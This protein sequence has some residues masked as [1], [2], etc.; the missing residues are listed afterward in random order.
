[1]AEANFIQDGIDRVESAFENLE[2][3]YKRLSKRAEKRRKEFEKQTEA[4]VRRFQRDLRNNAVVK[5]VQTLRDDARKAAQD[6]VEQMLGS[7]SIA[8]R[9]EVRRLDRKVAQLNKKIRELEK[10]P[11][12]TAAERSAS[13]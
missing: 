1:M 3:E 10:S 2:K 4:R 6:G 7:L 9:S 13:A 11:R 12:R 5:R 8:T